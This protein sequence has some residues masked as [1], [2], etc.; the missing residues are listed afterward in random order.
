MKI[1][2]GFPVGYRPALAGTTAAQAGAHEAQRRPYRQR[3]AERPF[4]PG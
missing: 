4:K 2:E 1:A 3:P